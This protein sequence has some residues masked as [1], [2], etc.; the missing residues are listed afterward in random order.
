MA[1][2]GC[3]YLFV[4]LFC[5]GPRASL[6][7]KPKEVRAA[8]V[9]CGGLCPG[10]NSVI[11]HIVLT[12]LNIYDAEK[13]RRLAKGRGIGFGAGSS[14]EY[15]HALNFFFCCA[16]H[17]STLLSTMT[18][19]PD[20]CRLGSESITHPLFLALESVRIN[21]K[22]Y[23]IQRSGRVVRAGQVV[24]PS[25]PRSTPSSSN[26]SY[27]DVNMDG[28]LAATQYSRGKSFTPNAPKPHPPPSGLW[29]CR[30]LRGF[31]GREPAP[32]GADS[33]RC[34]VD[35][36]RGRLNSGVSHHSRYR[37]SRL[38]FVERK[39]GYWTCALC[40]RTS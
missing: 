4:F 1:L 37:P 13:V 31:L 6:H 10:L 36:A 16:G 25:Y 8:V 21:W 17:L 5:S 7:F 22:V 35:S 12:L 11:H 23:P 32:G 34:R 19:Y 9:T 40:S 20:C 2:N 18:T 15:E 26:T 14:V 30:R 29:H 27:S 33:E 39:R 38:A 28:V 3:A 24:T